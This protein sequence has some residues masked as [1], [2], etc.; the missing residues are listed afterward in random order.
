MAY[1]HAKI[2]YIKWGR[3]TELVKG[4]DIVKIKKAAHS[5]PGWELAM[6]L[7]GYLETYHY[8]SSQK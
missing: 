7:G 2:E 3:H 1:D 4:K 5:G 6:R 8:I